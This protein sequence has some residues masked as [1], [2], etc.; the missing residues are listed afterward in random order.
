MNQTYSKLF[1]LS[2]QSQFEWLTGFAE[3]AG[4]WQVNA[5]NE[6]TFTINHKDAQVL[7]KIKRL[8]K[9]GQVTGPHSIQNGSIHYSYRVANLKGTKKLIQ[10]FNGRLVFNRSQQ[11]FKEYVDSYNSSGSTENILFNNTR[12]TPTLRDHWLSGFIEDRCLFQGS[13]QKDVDGKL[14]DVKLRFSFSQ[15]SE[16]ETMYHLAKLLKAFISE[17]KSTNTICIHA[18]GIKPRTRLIRYLNAH[19]LH[20]NKTISYERFKKLHVRLTDGEF[21]W[22]LTSRRARERIITLVRNLNLI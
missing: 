9:Y 3:S 4:S 21:Q 19:P 7:Y 1:T 6:P 14:Q 5:K 13:L 17:D 2:K 16:P 18:G 20:S 11:S 22:R 8:V 10:I 15:K 12:H